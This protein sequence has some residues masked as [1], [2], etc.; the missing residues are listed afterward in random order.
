MSEKY[1]MELKI[2]KQ[3]LL[4]GKYLARYIGSRQHRLLGKEYMFGLET[5]NGITK[6]VQADLKHLLTVDAT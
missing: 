6:L 5:S 2:G 1:H 3:Y 4:W